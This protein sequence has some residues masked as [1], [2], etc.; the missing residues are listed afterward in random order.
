MSRMAKLMISI[1]VLSVFLS[2]STAFALCIN[3]DFQYYDSNPKNI[4]QGS[5]SATT[6]V[7]AAK[8]K[9]GALHNEMRAKTR[10]YNLDGSTSINESALYKNKTGTISARVYAKD[11]CAKSAKG[12]YQCKCHICNRD[13]HGYMYSGNVNFKKC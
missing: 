6:Y 12:W 11:K 7:K 2:A 10:L 5:D 1:L 4:F 9:E 13:T 3:D 8:C